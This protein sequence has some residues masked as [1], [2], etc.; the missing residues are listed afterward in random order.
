[1]TKMTITPK[2]YNDISAGIV[3][4]LNPPGLPPLGVPIR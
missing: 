1:M 3:E 4:L 2:N